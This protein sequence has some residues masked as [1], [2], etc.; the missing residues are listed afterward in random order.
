MPV[1]RSS[2]NR[3]DLSLP[4]PRGEALATSSSGASQQS[5]KGGSFLKR[6]SST[7]SLLSQE[8][9][10]AGSPA[11]IGGR[12]NFSQQSPR[13]DRAL[14][15]S[16]TRVLAHQ[17]AAVMQQWPLQEAT[18]ESRIVCQMSQELVAELHP[19]A[20]SVAFQQSSGD[21]ST[22]NTSSQLTKEIQQASAQAEVSTQAT[23]AGNQPPRDLFDDVDTGDVG[24]VK[25]DH[26]PADRDT[27]LGSGIQDGAGA[28]SVDADYDPEVDE[29]RE[30]LVLGS[31]ASA[32][33]GERSTPITIGEPSPSPHAD[34]RETPNSERSS[35]EIGR[36]QD[37][38]ISPFM[39]RL[40][41]SQETFHYPTPPSRGCLSSPFSPSVNANGQLQPQYDLRTPLLRSSSLG[42]N[43]SGD[44]KDV[45]WPT[46]QRSRHIT[47]S[48][49]RRPGD[50]SDSFD[51]D[52]TGE[53]AYVF[54][55][56]QGSPENSPPRSKSGSWWKKLSCCF[57]ASS[58]PASPPAADTPLLGGRSLTDFLNEQNEHR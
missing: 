37:H 47:A 49:G 45:L 43:R 40:G 22:T 10:E 36:P 51:A 11:L 55:S 56:G 28:E 33:S 44:R 21:G 3:C 20:R 13:V 14:R 29:L 7:V 8:S 58:Q 2:S 23:A 35:V 52:G 38:T 53:S 24:L 41:Q 25:N 57:G 30:A 19:E 26:R 39:E 6:S 12:S 48:T 42:Q 46:S 31:P 15:R 50:L 16:P 54:F 5:S 9:E 34:S 32:H 1:T 18:A 17:M 4:L 27:K